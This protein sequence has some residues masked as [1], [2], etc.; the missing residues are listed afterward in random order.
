MSAAPVSAAPRGA[1]QMRLEDQIGFL[2]DKI[3]S[4]ADRERDCRE[5]I[6]G[7]RGG[8][9]D[10]VDCHEGLA[11]RLAGLRA[12][13]AEAQRRN[14]ELARFCTDWSSWVRGPC[15]EGYNL[16]ASRRRSYLQAAESM[17]PLWGEVANRETSVAVATARAQLEAIQLQKQEAVRHLQE[18]HRLG[19]E[20][21]QL[22]SELHT[23]QKE[24]PSLYR[25]LA[26][27]TL[28]PRDNLWGN[29]GD[30]AAAVAADGNATGTLG[31]CRLAPASTAVLMQT[32][33]FDAQ[34]TRRHSAVSPVTGC[35][36]VD[37]WRLDAGL[38]TML[39]NTLPSPAPQPTRPP[40]PTA[41][42]AKGHDMPTACTA[43]PKGDTW[44]QFISAPFMTLTPSQAAALSSS[45]GFVG[46]PPLPGGT[47][48]QGDSV[49]TAVP[50]RDPLVGATSV[51][52]SCGAALV[53]SPLLGPPSV[54][55]AQQDNQ[56]AALNPAP[57]LVSAPPVVAAS[58]ALPV[59]VAQTAVAPALDVPVATLPTSASHAPIVPES[60][61]PAAAPPADTAPPVSAFT[62]PAPV[63]TTTSDGSLRV[64]ASCATAAEA[65]ELMADGPT[66]AISPAAE[67]AKVESVIPEMPVREVV[68]GVGTSTSHGSVQTL[69]DVRP[70]DVEV[71]TASLI[72][73]D[74]APSEKVAETRT[75]AVPTVSSG[76]AQRPVPPPLLTPKVS[77]TSVACDPQA[78]TPG[79]LEKSSESILAPEFEALS[80]PCAATP[81]QAAT[82]RMHETLAQTSG[83]AT[84]SDSSIPL[85]GLESQA[86]LRESP[87]TPLE[88]PE[89]L[90]NAI[91][92]GPDCAMPTSTHAPSIRVVEPPPET[93]AGATSAPPSDHEGASPLSAVD[94][95]KSKVQGESEH[96]PP[97]TEQ[98]R[99]AKQVKWMV[100]PIKG[101]SCSP[102]DVRRF[103]REF[104][105]GEAWAT[106]VEEGLALASAGDV[107]SL[108]TALDELAEPQV[109]AVVL[110][111]V[112]KHME[113]DGAKEGEGAI[114][115][116]TSDVSELLRLL[117][118][119]LDLT[120]WQELLSYLQGLPPGAQDP[121]CK[122]IAECILPLPPFRAEQVRWLGEALV[123]FMRGEAS[124]PL[125]AS[126][127]A[128]H[129]GRDSAPSKAVGRGGAS[130]RG[131]GGRGIGALA[132]GARG[133]HSGVGGGGRGGGDASGAVSGSVGITGSGSGFTAG[134]RPMGGRG[135]GGGGVDLGIAVVESDSEDDNFG[136]RRAPSSGPSSTTGKGSA[137]GGGGAGFMGGRGRGRGGKVI[138]DSDDSDD[139]PPP[140]ASSGGTAR[141]SAAPPL[142]QSS[143]KQQKQQFGFGSATSMKSPG[144][145]GQV[146]AY[147]MRKGS[148]S[149]LTPAN[150]GGGSSV[151][152]T[153]RPP[154]GGGRASLLSRI[155]HDPAWGKATVS[156]PAVGS[157]DEIAEL[158]DF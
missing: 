92:P 6:L 112:R 82:P 158:E 36:G 98:Q 44:Q 123:R 120:P 114:Q 71:P 134:A 49:A 154:A 153:Y 136:V 145:A 22:H 105:R 1:Q 140:H 143:Y 130:G 74:S 55:A 29:A 24:L 108:D 14:A 40:T 50:C 83:A 88:K 76:P 11:Q 146:S 45:A 121:L 35:Q 103:L 77:P 78:T 4:L 157:D 19:S 61:P 47:Q 57:L 15:K 16:V 89:A 12:E 115:M 107:S 9:R 17:L 85:G 26:T 150:S 25:A 91:T 69:A 90:A 116:L 111:L 129:G 84:S 21:R 79:G 99:L 101:V 13:A 33:I 96:S 144:T 119:G 126:T 86:P 32:P 122:V 66:A 5:R 54:P 58:V 97:L 42:A 148:N 63:E 65:V 100:E 53:P 31:C 156:A 118:V 70:V 18:S 127:P 34:T 106:S 28:R 95:T 137:R 135:A 52:T 43:L 30:V 94:Q 73:G 46:C 56:V 124:A 104:S 109:L 139:D 81:S 8:E 110:D 117:E 68:A 10:M 27:D 133:S 102:M 125:G 60:S 147:S 62:V 75:L 64:V 3:A 51:Q 80:R 41:F 128:G 39:G 152:P 48:P 67:A 142:S 38:S 93:P 87:E 23:Q 132:D 59:S 20:L 141:S 138:E 155:Q 2:S 72:A 7:A 131:G 113:R 37:Q 149:A 151:S